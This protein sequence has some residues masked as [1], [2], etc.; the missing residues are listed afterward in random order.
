[1]SFE[2]EVK[3]LQAQFQ[4]SKEKRKIPGVHIFFYESNSWD[5]RS[6]SLRNCMRLK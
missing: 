4:K 6:A 2:E 1:M 5:S 3:L